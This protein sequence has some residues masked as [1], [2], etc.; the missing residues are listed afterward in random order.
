LDR[1]GQPYRVSATGWH[2]RI[3]QHEIDHLEG[4]IY[5]DRMHPWSFVH[6]EHYVQDWRFRPIPDVRAA[7]GAG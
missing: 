6:E 3:I 1:D 2:A 5:V 4:M 7:F